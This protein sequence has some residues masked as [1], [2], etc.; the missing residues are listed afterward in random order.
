MTR[1][2]F[3]TFSFLVGA[4][5]VAV[6]AV[7]LS[8]EVTIQLIDLRVV[9]PVLLLAL[10]LALLVGRADTSELS[11]LDDPEATGSTAPAERSHEV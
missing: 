1:H 7:V 10:G 4:I 8:G 2:R 6:G 5:A 3:D 11:W 9:G